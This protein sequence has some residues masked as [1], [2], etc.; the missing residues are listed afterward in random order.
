MPLFYLQ[1]VGQYSSCWLSCLLVIGLILNYVSVAWVTMGT[2]EEQPRRALDPLNVELQ[3]S[4]HVSA[5]NLTRV[6]RKS[7]EC[8]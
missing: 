7:S 6:P 3:V 2:N 8:S 5:G 4:Y 1:A